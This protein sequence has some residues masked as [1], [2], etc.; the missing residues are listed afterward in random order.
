MKGWNG[1]ILWI[2]LNKEE[3][4]TIEYPKEWAAEYLGGRGLAIRILWEYNK[5]G[6]DPFSPE[7]L[8]IFAIGPLSGMPIPS[9]GKLQVASK[10][11]LTGGYGDGNIGTLF[12]VEMRKSGLDAI[13]FYGKSEKPLLLNIENDKVSF[14][15]ADDL[16]GLD[17]WETEEKLR[18]RFGRFAGMV[19]IGPGGENLVRFAT[20]MSQ[21]GRSGGR[22]GIGA[23]MGSKKIKAVVIKGT[24]NVELFDEKN[25]KI[26]GIKALKEVRERPGYNFWMREGTMATVDWAQ[27]ASVLPTYNFSE[28][29]FDEYK[30]IDGYTMESL[31]VDQRGCPGCNMQCGNVILDTEGNKSELDYENVA[32]L[33]SNLGIPRLQDVAVLNT[34]ADKYGLDTIS[35]GGVL[36]WGTEASQK[37]ILNVDGRKLE[38]G[39]VKTYKELVSEI[40]FRKTELGNILA[41]GTMHA[42]NKVGGCDFAVNAKGLEVSA[43]DCHTAPGMALAFSTSPIGAHH[44]DAWVISWEVQNDRFSYDREKA[45]KVIELQ[46]IR[47]GMFESITTCRLPWVEI[48]L[49]LE[50]YPL[51]LTYA[52]GI[53][54]TWDTIYD[55]ADRIYALIRAFW[56]REFNAWDRKYDMPPEKW[57]KYPLTKGPL[58][59]GRLSYEGYNQLLDHYYDLRGW[60]KNGV[61]KI[62]TLKRLNLEFVI[63]TLE[64]IVKLS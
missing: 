10:S 3:A 61:P 18:K 28:G 25:F 52:T 16:W 8:L 34:L 20:V 42:C 51:L 9:S 23:V 56:I 14:E 21:E 35:L 47:G 37:G 55:V 46:R 24:K 64:K 2:D 36:G 48:G 1:N 32:I 22:P 62:E 49:N 41:E 63:P 4:K 30:G 17:S 57:F 29:V 50:H 58:K 60:D 5:P 27:E 31:K 26:E 12:S 59:G 39:D 54:Y 15:N 11:P 44:K 7:N 6:I 53:K 43:Y 33:G 13:V 45:A 40:A 38:W 19:E